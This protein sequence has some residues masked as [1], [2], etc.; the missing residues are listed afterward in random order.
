MIQLVLFLPEQ[1]DACAGKNCCY[2]KANEGNGAGGRSG[3]IGRVGNRCIG[4]RCIG[5]RLVGYGIVSYR[6]ISNGLIGNRLIGYRLV[7]YGFVGY[8]FVGYDGGGSLNGDV[9]AGGYLNLVDVDG[10]LVGYVIV[11]LLYTSPSPRDR[12]KSRMP[13]SA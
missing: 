10:E 2:A 12:Q 9:A 1:D 7:S 11:C 4:Y 3:R 5:Y 13:S 8:R 6:N